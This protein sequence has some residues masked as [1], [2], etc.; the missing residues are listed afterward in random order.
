MLSIGAAKLLFWISLGLLVYSYVGYLVVSLALSRLV[1]LARGG[2]GVPVVEEHA[3]RVT[4]V[5]PAH[6]E[7]LVIEAKLRNALALEYP[8][9]RLEILVVDDGSTDQTVAIVEQFAARGV[10]LWTSAGRRGKTAALNAAAAT[11][12]G[13]VLCLCDAN[14][15]FAPDALSRL[16]ARLADPRVGAVSGDVRLASQEANFEYG[17]RLYYVLERR[18]QAA[19]SRLGSLM[20]VDG[21]MYVVRRELFTALPED[22]ILD[23]FVTT[24]RVIRRGFRVVFEPL[25]T[26]TENGTPTARA[27]WVRRVRLSAG[28]AQVLKRWETPRLVQP[29]ECW[30]Y[31]S[32]KLLRLCDPALLVGWL[33]TSLVLAPWGQVYC[34]A[35][36]AQVVFYVLAAIGAAVVPFRRTALGGVPFYFVLGHLGLAWG[37]VCGVFDW[38]PVTW[39]RTPRSGDKEMV[40]AE[41]SA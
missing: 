22:T 8:H 24:M 9:D 35:W 2:A 11:A 38:Q 29:I 16:V 41:R 5:I 19:E 18:L 33:V 13:Q 12:T 31:V 14:V 27:E 23:D 20:G 1:R 4:L 21:G 39:R 32:H 17:E 26:A 10:R 6:N 28:A 37:V 25:A 30:Q 15:M 40:A 34:L 7:A 3:P 36:G